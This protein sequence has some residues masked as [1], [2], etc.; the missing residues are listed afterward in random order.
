M[1]CSIFMHHPV[2]VGVT[3]PLVNAYTLRC[4]PVV[5]LPP[6]E[7]N[8][9]AQISSDLFG[10]VCDIRVVQTDVYC[11]LFTDMF[12]VTKPA[13]KRGDKVKVI[14]PPMRLDKIIICGLRDVGR[15]SVVNPLT[16]TLSNRPL[17]SRT[18]IGTLA[19]DG[20]AVTFGTARRPLS[21][22]LAVPNVTAHPS[23]A[24]VPTSYY[25][26]WHYTIIFAL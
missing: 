7:Y 13:T 6:G 8:C 21:I 12:L 22:L 24:S 1:K 14:K 15:S 17:D 10:R 4:W 18:V 11:F 3:G 5:V 19:V 25:L 2:G 16:G 23:T 20:W 9:N 26:I